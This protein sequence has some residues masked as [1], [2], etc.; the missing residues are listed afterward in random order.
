MNQQ[1][2]IFG[3]L[4]ITGIVIVA[5]ALSANQTGAKLVQA[6]LAIAILGVLLRQRSD[7]L[8]AWNHITS[9]AI[10]VTQTEASS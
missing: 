7:F 8:A 2:L 3:V 10:G 1:Q 5:M 6:G 9:K 4:A